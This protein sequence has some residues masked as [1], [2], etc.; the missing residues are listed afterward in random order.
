MA[1]KSKKR[2]KDSREKDW[3][4]REG[5]GKGKHKEREENDMKSE[6]E[7]IGIAKPTSEPVKELTYQQ[8]VIKTFLPLI[9]GVIAG[10]ISFFVTGDL[11]TRDPLSIVVLVLTIYINKFIMPNFDIELQGKDWAGIGFLTFTTWYISWTLLL[12]I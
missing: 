4:D 5:R 6:V 3:K 2:K 1:K 9:F 10:I 8:E 11:R 7:K 12:N